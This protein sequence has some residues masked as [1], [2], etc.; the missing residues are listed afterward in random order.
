VGH[1][2]TS[3]TTA[4]ELARM[5]VGREVLLRVEK[6]PARPG[7]AVLSVRELSIAGRDGARRLDR[8]SFEVRGGEIVGVGGVEGNGQTEVIEA[9]AVLLP[10]WHVAGTL[11][12]GG[13]DIGPLA[14]RRRPEACLAHVPE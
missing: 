1:V 14:W 11:A 7:A 4:A 5:M 8:V 9:L 12:F 6:P 3:E 10:G 2:K 13:R